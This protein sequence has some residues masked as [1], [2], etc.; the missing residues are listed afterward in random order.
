MVL[1]KTLESS[2]DCKEIKPVSPK[3]N[4]PW[5]FIGRTDAQAEVPTLWPPDE[6]SWF[7]GK[8]PDARRKVW[9]RMRL[10]D[11]IINSMDGLSKLWEVVK[12]REAWH[13]AVHWGCKDSEMTKRL[14]DSSIFKWYLGFALHI[15][16]QT[17]SSCIW[18]IV[19]N[20]LLR[21]FNEIWHK[22]KTFVSVT[23]SSPTIIM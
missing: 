13:I 2:L 5:I 15:S 9:Q 20:G 11:S 21:I 4:Q 6:K 7:T 17:V 8:D 22:H 19:V 10:L 16:V 12:D 18:N 23:S 3:G 1:E 14:N